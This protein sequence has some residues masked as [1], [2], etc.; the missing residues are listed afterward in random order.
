M[1]GFDRSAPA[2]LSNPSKAEPVR[3]SAKLTMNW[4]VSL[5]SFPNMI[6]E[7]S[8]E[9]TNIHANEQMK[10]VASTLDLINE[11]TEGAEYSND[12][13]RVVRAVRVKIW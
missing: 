7:M 8:A 9:R 3:V 12:E 6:I 4:M 10:A 1:F 13:A 2:M 5:L 11:A